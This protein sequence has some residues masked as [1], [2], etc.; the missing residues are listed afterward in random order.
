ML[1]GGHPH[2]AAHVCRASCG[3]KGSAFHNPI[4]AHTHTHLQV[5]SWSLSAGDDCVLLLS[6]GL[7]DLLSCTDA[8]VLSHLYGTAEMQSYLEVGRAGTGTAAA[9]G[10]R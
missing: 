5:G 1:S 8:A 9:A 6:S 7:L 2:P 4:A 3:E 10:G